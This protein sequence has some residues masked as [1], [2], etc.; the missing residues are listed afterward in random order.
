MVGLT[1]KRAT[2]G[3]T[4]IITAGDSPQVRAGEPKKLGLREI[5]GWRFPQG[6]DP[7]P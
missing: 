4:E 7:V 6:W 3:S 2:L 5:E 1:D